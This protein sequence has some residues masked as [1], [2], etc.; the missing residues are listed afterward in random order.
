[1]L[2]RIRTLKQQTD[3]ADNLT[4]FGNDWIVRWWPVAMPAG[5]VRGRPGCREEGG[6]VLRERGEGGEGA[7]DE[8]PLVVM[9]EFGSMEW[10]TSSVSR[11]GLYRLEPATKKGDA[12]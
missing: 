12:D 6:G 8:A 7:G 2:D 3:T 1:M 11:C 10:I 4:L 5:W 9:G